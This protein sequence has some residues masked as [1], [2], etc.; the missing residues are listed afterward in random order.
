MKREG[1]TLIELLVVIAVIALLMAITVPSLRI[2]KL[3]AEAVKCQSNIRQLLISLKMYEGDNG[4]FP[5]AVDTTDSILLNLSPGGFAGEPP[6]DRPGWWWFNHIADYSKRDFDKESLIWCP[7]R[8]I[9]GMRLAYNVLC[10]NYGVNLSICKRSTSGK[11]HTEFLGT[12]LSS[13]NISPPS[14][15]LL[16]LDSGYSM[17]N[18]WH[19]TDDPPATLVGSTNENNA[20]VPGLEI[21]E[22]MPLWPGQDFDAN[23][24]RHPNKTVNVGFADGHIERKEAED[25]LVEKTNDGYKNSYPLWQPIKSNDNY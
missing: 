13:I 14:Q 24:G 18:W 3:Q 4:T 7:S 25:L 11:N 9:T 8:P 23:N 21:N 10:G 6:Y 19:V 15:T 22:G 5:H 2:V 1:F 16:I 20:Y 17:I 12:P